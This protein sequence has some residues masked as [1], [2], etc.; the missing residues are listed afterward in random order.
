[1]HKLLMKLIY[2]ARR[3]LFH[4]R[5]GKTQFAA[6]VYKIVFEAA[7]PDLTKPVVFRNTALY[8]DPSDR[9]C[10][11]SIVGGYFE[12]KE[13]DI[14]E[15]L[16]ADASVFFDVGANI[17]IYSVIGCLKSRE[18]KSYAFEPVTENQELLRKNIAAHRLE[19]RILVQPTAVSVH[20]GKATIHLY[21]S[22]THSLENDRGTNTRDVDTVSLDEFTAVQRVTP[23]IMK[24][25]VEGH[26]AKV[27]DGALKM[28][29][30][31]PPTV[32]IEYIPAAHRDVEGL[33]DR[34]RSVFQICFVV[35][36]ITNTVREIKTSELDRR[37]GYNLILTTNARHAEEIRRFVTA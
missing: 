12:Q 28:L 37:K 26:E 15:G 31:D 3:F 23:D 21:H 16:I 35:D 27:I 17:G 4:T 6:R 33:V 9:S 7:A 10:V 30:T 34:L 29:A 19:E 14:F 20:T 22:G 24:I 13:L 18:L 8:V 1:M 36:E 5:L 32:F 2:V 11:P 25:D